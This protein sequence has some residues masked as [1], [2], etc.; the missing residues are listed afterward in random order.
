VIN[1]KLNYFLFNGFPFHIQRV[2]LFLMDNQRTNMFYL[3]G[4][5]FHLGDLFPLDYHGYKNYENSF[6][7]YQSIHSW[8]SFL[9]NFRFTKKLYDLGIID[10]DKTVINLLN[11]DLREV[12]YM[13]E[14]KF[15]LT[16][17]NY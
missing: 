1:K 17:F 10:G 13:Y 16:N 6:S 12:M 9:A 5:N 11:K 15:S 4:I 14:E 7:F 3:S 2:M 8:H